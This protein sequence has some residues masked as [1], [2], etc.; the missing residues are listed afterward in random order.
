MKI[1]RINL[2]LCCGAHENLH[3]KFMAWYSVVSMDLNDY[4]S[5][6]WTLFENL[7][8]LWV[9][10]TRKT[11]VIVHAGSWKCGNGSWKGIEEALN[12]VV[13]AIGQAFRTLLTTQVAWPLAIHST[14]CL[15]LKIVA[16]SYRKIL[17]FVVCNHAYF[18]EVIYKYSAIM[19]HRSVLNN[20]TSGLREIAVAGRSE[21]KV[22]KATY[23]AINKYPVSTC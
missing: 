10:C 6:P 19:W 9:S 17:I 12:L 15:K 3:W 20:M 13:G 18:P 8:Y 23:R 5:I 22:T 1:W 2:C 11:N 14:R 4:K 16:S 7:R 21:E